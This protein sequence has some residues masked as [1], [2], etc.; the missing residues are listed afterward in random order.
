M[1]GARSTAELVEGVR[2]AAVTLAQNRLRSFL[3]TL[4]MVIGVMTGIAIVAIIQGLNTSFE[5]QVATFGANTLYISKWKWLSLSDDWWKMRNRKS[6]GKAELLAIGRESMLATAVAPQSRAFATVSHEGVELT[7]VQVNGTDWQYL[8]TAGGTVAYGR[9]LVESDTALARPVVVLGADVADQVFPAT[10]PQKIIG[11]EVAIA[12]RR[13][14]IIGLMQRRGAFLGDSLDANVLMPYSTFSPMFGS[15]RSWSIAVAGAPTTLRALEDEL[16]GILRRVRAVPHEAEDDFSINRQE[17]LLKVYQQ[18]TGALYAVAV[19]VG[20]ITLIVGGIGIM[21]IMLV[22][23]HE[24]TR[25]IGIR[26]ALGARRRTILFQFII[27]SAIVAAVGGGVGTFLG[28]GV[29]Q[30][31]A[32]VSPLAAAATGSA[33]LLGFGFSALVGVVFGSFPAWRAANLD[34]VEALRYE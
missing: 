8:E 6:I 12:G 28:L 33:V 13:F 10:L 17:Q 32:L 26:R 23:V 30:L 4:G 21:N 24:R 29:A 9:F 14:R 27:E 16:T 15:R 5:A 31:V 3:T 11:D 18:L 34:P 7:S 19:G 25:E 22:A 2:L 1:I 20:L